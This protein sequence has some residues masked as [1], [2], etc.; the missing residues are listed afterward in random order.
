[1]ECGKIKGLDVEML[2][3]EI[4]NGIWRN[5]FK[6]LRVWKDWTTEQR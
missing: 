1:M 3:R 5:A 6:V 2:F 4:N